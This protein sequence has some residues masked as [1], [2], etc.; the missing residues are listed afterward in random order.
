M[1]DGAQRDVLFSIMRH[2]MIDTVSSVLAV[3]DGV[4]SLEG[5]NGSFKLL[6]DGSDIAGSLQDR[7]LAAEE[8]QSQ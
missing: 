3:V 4:S 1:L 2:V 8:E 5:R 7:F 6:V